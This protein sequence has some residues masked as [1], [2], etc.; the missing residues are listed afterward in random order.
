MAPDLDG[1]A[2][3]LAGISRQKLQ[4]AIDFRLMFALGSI[5]AQM[6]TILDLYPTFA[7]AWLQTKRAR[8]SALVLSG[9][10]Y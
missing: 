4:H 7:R 10:A 9:A 5:C 2:G 3:Q 1:N 8:S 6:A